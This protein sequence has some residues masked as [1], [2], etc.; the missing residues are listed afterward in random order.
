LPTGLP[1]LSLGL[2]R[3]STPGPRTTSTRCASTLW[4]TRWGR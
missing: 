1:F 4:C 2:P 3:S